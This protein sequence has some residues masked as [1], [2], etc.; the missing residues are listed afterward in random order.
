MG[1]KLDE[2]VTRELEQALMNE[3]KLRP[4]IIQLGHERFSGMCRRV[5]SVCSDYLHTGWEQAAVVFM[6]EPTFYF[7]ARLHA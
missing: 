1:D 3:L 4:S 5:L 2:K 6:G 7:I